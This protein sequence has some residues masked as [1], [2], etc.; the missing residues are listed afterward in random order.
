MSRL[1]NR[2]LVAL[3]VP[4]VVT[5]VA[6]TPL[7]AQQPTAPA[8]HTVKKG[9]TLWD[10][11]KRYLGDA[12]LWP[13]IYRL[14]TETI[15]DPHWIYPGELL[16]LPGAADMAAA[17]V[18]AP[19]TADDIRRPNE[20]MTIF[21]PAMNKTEQISRE[22]LI[23]GARATAVRAGEFTASPFAWAPGG[24]AQGGKIDQTTEGQGIAMTV[25]DRP[26]QAREAVF[27]ILPKGVQGVVGERLLAYRLGPFLV[28]QG[29]VI[30]PTGILS[31]TR[32][33]R[34][35][36]ARAELLTKFEDVFPGNLVSALDTLAMPGNVFPQR[37][38]FGLSTRVTWLYNDPVLPT[39]GQF[40]II[41]AREKDGLAPGDQL[42]LRRD[43]GVDANGNVLPDE[44]I[45]VAQVTRVTQWGASAIV[46]QQLQPGIQPGMPA[47]VTA[48]MP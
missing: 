19:T 43:R 23:L 3:F 14:N 10:L 26:I 7:A 6:A 20:R 22:T 42:S 41:A 4:C 17:P 25:L 44:E 24:P 31:I 45:A 36:R 37:V 47:R 32:P 27:V 35:G 1:R 40:L 34:D 2:L 5:A 38:E 39:A 28:D 11:A 15:E 46:I 12:Y 18:S 8:T 33:A 13:E 21:N 16:R 48:K 9:D 29:Q 30:I